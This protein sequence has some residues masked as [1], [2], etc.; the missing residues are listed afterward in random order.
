MQKLSE[1]YDQG[2]WYPRCCGVKSDSW[3][4]PKFP[5]VVQKKQSQKEKDIEAAYRLA[6]QGCY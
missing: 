5:K 4:A 6:K 3:Q 1:K 2:S